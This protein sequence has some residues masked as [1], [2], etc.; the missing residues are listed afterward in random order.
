MYHL[1]ILALALSVLQ[2]QSLPTAGDIQAALIR[3]DFLYFEA[4]FADSISLLQPL[5]AALEAQADRIPE[6]IAIK[7]SLALAHIGLNELDAGKALFADIVQLDPTFSLAPERFAPKVIKLFEEAQAEN[8]N[9]CVTICNAAV[10]ERRAGNVDVALQQVRS[11]PQCACSTAVTL[12]VAETVYR[13]GIELYKQSNLQDALKEFRKALSLAPQHEL[14]RQYVQLIQEKNRVAAEQHLLDWRKNFTAGDFAKA[15]AAY[16]DLLSISGE[17]GTTVLEQVRN[18]Y[19]KALASFVGSWTEACGKHDGVEM[20][21]VR[22]QAI[23]MVPEETVGREFL[24]QMG[25]CAS[26]RPCIRVDSAMMLSRIRS[27]TPFSSPVVQVFEGRV[28]RVQINIDENGNTSVEQ[29]SGGNTVIDAFLKSALEEWKF[30]PT[31]VDGQPRCVSTE[32]KL[33]L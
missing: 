31:I 18:E 32:M 20:D 4:R 33:Q 6:R 29:L 9:S 7:R 25:S 5:V 16:R 8:R 19:Q 10:R 13:Q 14:A 24:A 26:K 30:V 22:Q 12:D 17:G 28:V 2:Q 1:I 21:R 27:F 11:A 3:G 23:Q 15:A